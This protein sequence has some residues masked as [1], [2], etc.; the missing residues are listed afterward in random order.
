MSSS[1]RRLKVTKK[2]RMGDLHNKY[3]VYFPID[4]VISYEILVSL[5]LKLT[6]KYSFFDKQVKDAARFF[7]GNKESLVWYN[8]GKSIQSDLINVTSIAPTT[9]QTRVGNASAKNIRVGERNNYL[10]KGHASLLQKVTRVTIL[11]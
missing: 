9:N 10:L 1:L 7:F 6:T 5:L 11:L 4:E 2:K 8:P 3:H